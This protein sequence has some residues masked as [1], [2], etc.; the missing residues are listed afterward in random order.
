MAGIVMLDP[1][2]ACCSPRHPNKWMNCSRAVCSAADILICASVPEHTVNHQTTARADLIP[3]FKF[4]QCAQRGPPGASGTPERVFTKTR[5]TQNLTD[6]AY[7]HPAALQS[8]T[9]SVH[10]VRHAVQVLEPRLSNTRARRTI[11]TSVSEGWLPHLKS[12]DVVPSKIRE[13]LDCTVGAAQFLI[14]AYFEDCCMFRRW[15]RPRCV[16]STLDTRGATLLLQHC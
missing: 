9:S 12:M 4:G 13:A 5:L 1:K 16:V 11:G 6:A 2:N 7:R 8:I 14:V 3:T 15:V 10:F